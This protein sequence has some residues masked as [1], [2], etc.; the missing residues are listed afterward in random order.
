MV[1]LCSEL[2]FAR[3]SGVAEA[4]LEA[5]ERCGS[6]GPSAHGPA[7]GRGTGRRSAP[8]DDLVER[9]FLPY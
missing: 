7:Q 2:E 3:G 1:D 4:S 9:A 8:F 6:V 5:V